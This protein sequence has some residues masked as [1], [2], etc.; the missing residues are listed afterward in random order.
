MD[1]ITYIRLGGGKLCFW[2]EIERTAEPLDIPTSLFYALEI[3]QQE[4]YD[5]KR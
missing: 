2:V 5:T 4:T 1:T 3:S